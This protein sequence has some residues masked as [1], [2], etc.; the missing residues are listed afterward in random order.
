MNGRACMTV[1]GYLPEDV[2]VAGL[3]VEVMLLNIQMRFVT[4]EEN[5]MLNALGQL[6]TTKVGFERWT[7][8]H[9]GPLFSDISLH[10]K[11]QR[12]QVVKV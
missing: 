6:S 2:V 8:N 3:Q 11:H 5:I 1:M 7:V 10:C 4:E 12:L 9:T